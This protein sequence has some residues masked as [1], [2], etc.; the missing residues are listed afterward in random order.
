MDEIEYKWKRTLYSKTFQVGYDTKKRLISLRQ[1]HYRK[2]GKL[3]EIDLRPK[4]VKGGWVVHSPH[5]KCEIIAFPFEIR[6]A[7]N[8]YKNLDSPDTN[9]PSYD[10]GLIFPRAGIDIYFRPNGI[11]IS[12]KGTWRING[13]V[14]DET[15]I[16]VDVTPSV[17]AKTVAEFLSE[18]RSKVPGE[19]ISHKFIKRK[20]RSTKREDTAMLEVV[21]RHDQAWFNTD[22]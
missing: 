13:E 20:T 6:I 15:F 16:R 4:E 1:L 18:T 3:T 10:D 19:I 17:N 8:S 2:D 7:G 5:Y 22:Q 14:R 21:F 12:G 11:E 9:L